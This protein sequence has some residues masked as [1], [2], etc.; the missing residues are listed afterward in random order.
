VTPTQAKFPSYKRKVD[1]EVASFT[2]FAPDEPCDD[3][4]DGRFRG[5]SQA[6]TR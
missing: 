5:G 6:P 1:E 4:L 2:F 3:L